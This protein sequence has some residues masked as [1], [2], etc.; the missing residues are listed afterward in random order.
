MSKFFWLDDERTPPSD[1]WV[2]FDSAEAIISALGK[3]HKQVE[4]ISLDHDLGD[5]L[6]YG[7]GYEVM[8]WIELQVHTDS[9]FHCPAIRFHTQNPEGRRMMTLALVSIENKLGR[10]VFRS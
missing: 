3:L 5:R 4:I 2:W 9:G 6:I 7:D 10:R 1:E 8:K